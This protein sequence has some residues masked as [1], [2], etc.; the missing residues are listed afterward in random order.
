MIL[1]GRLVRIDSRR[2]QVWIAA[3]GALLV[4]WRLAEG[5]VTGTAVVV[6]WLAG[7]LLAVAAVGAPLVAPAGMLAGA[8]VW[9]ALRALWPMAGVLAGAAAGIASAASVADIALLTLGMLAGIL[10]TVRCRASPMSLALCEADAVSLA[11]SLAG[12]AGLG[13]WLLLPSRWP[14]AVACLAIASVWGGAWAAV[15]AA[16]SGDRPGRRIC[17]PL[18]RV[19][20]TSQAAALA[21]PVRRILVAASMA[22]SLGG[23]VAGL[24]LVSGGASVAGWVA[25]ACFVAIAVPPTLLPDAALFPALGR[26]LATIPPVAAGRHASAATA[27]AWWHAAILA[28]PP[29]VAALLLVREPSRALAAILVALVP[30]LAALVISIVAS[31]RIF[32]ASAETRLAMAMVA[33]AVVAAASVGP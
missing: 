29:L 32:R 20:A 21:S 13:V 25:L 11:L 6:A 10:A 23:M 27:A 9:A 31:P 5:S 1:L 19:S 12:G 8:G 30:V 3:I 7:A 17:S 4:A 15:L 22:V 33:A 24:F 18:V 16:Q 28:W 26:F 14:P 2:P